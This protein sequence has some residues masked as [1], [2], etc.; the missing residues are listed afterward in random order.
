MLKISLVPKPKIQKKRFWQRI[1]FNMKNLQT[2]F[3]VKLTQLGMFTT[4]IR[5][6]YS[7]KINIHV[8]V[9]L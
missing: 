8:F 6:T 3:Y 4:Y 7:L 9:I 2:R 1:T 5:W